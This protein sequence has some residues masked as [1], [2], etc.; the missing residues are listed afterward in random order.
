MANTP[1]G[2][3]YRF[4]AGSTTSTAIVVSSDVPVNAWEFL[5][6]GAQPIQIKFFTGNSTASCFVSFPALGGAGVYDAAIQHGAL[7]NPTIY[8]PN[9]LVDDCA[10]FGGFTST[11]VI[12]AIAESGT[13]GLFITPVQPNQG[14]N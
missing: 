2:P 7:P 9:R 11:I 14:S 12:A 3:T 13:Q 10:D 6:D 1:A 4:S 5:N 8:L